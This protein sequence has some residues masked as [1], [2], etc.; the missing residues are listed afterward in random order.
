MSLGPFCYARDRGAC[1]SR[2][3]QL[4]SSPAFRTETR[5]CKRLRSGSLVPQGVL[6]MENT[7][8]E[9]DFV[10]WT[11]AQAKALR[12][13]AVGGN[14]PLDWENLAEEIESLGRSERREL[15]SRITR[16]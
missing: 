9:Q 14:T 3:L 4:G 8:Y 1:D 15:R 12:E 5:A 11:E 6:D 2:P 7:L 10:L 16:I 13:A